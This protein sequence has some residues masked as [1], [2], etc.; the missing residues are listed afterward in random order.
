MLQLYYQVLIENFRL[1]Y[2]IEVLAG[3]SQHWAARANSVL[4]LAFK[5][6]KASASISS[7][8]SKSESS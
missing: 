4:D 2:N 5:K 7:I 6:D 3:L 8:R 1:E